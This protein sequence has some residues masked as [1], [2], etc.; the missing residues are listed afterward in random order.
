MAKKTSEIAFTGVLSGDG[1]CF[2]WDDVHPPDVAQ[3][4]NAYMGQVSPDSVFHFLARGV[5]GD[6][7]KPDQRYRFMIRME[8]INDGE[9]GVS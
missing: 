7:P 8:E 9:D 5:A 4:L 6:N 3:I 2:C 1:E